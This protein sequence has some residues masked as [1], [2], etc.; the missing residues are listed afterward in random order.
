[1]VAASDP[2]AD[3]QRI[4]LR[5]PIGEIADRRLQYRR[6]DLHR[7]RDQPDL[8][9]AEPIGILQHR[10]QRR[11]QRLDHVVEKMREAQR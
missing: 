4:G 2:H 3:R 5:P 1:M 8:R 7:Q 6:G 11:H 9:E 10:I